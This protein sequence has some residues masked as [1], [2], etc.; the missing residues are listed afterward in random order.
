MARTTKKEKDVYLSP[1]EQQIM[2]IIYRSDRGI[3]ATEVMEGLPDDLSNSA[4]RTFLR[5]LEHKGHLKHDEKDG[6]YIYK[7]TTP[8]TRP[9]APRRASSYRRSSRVPSQRPW[10]RFW[11]TPTPPSEPRSS[12]SS[13]PSWRRPARA[14]H[15]TI[16]REVAMV[17]LILATLLAFCAPPPDSPSLVYLDALLAEPSTVFEGN[18]HFRAVKRVQFGSQQVGHALVSEAHMH[19]SAPARYSSVSFALGKRYKSFE[20]ILGRDN[21]EQ[22]LGRSV[23]HLRLISEAFGRGHKPS[24]TDD[25]PNAACGQRWPSMGRRKR[26]PG[27]KRRGPSRAWGLPTICST[28]R[29]ACRSASSE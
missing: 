24:D 15:S 26:G 2:E 14:P 7:P 27:R 19:R 23:H 4:V 3:S 12:T 5:I 17:P 10:R 29:A 22:E 16:F 8:A 6:R 18:A 21:A 13:P 11:P 9:P 28:R 25:T 1:R 20:A